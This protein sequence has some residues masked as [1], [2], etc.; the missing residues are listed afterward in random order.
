M[1]AFVIATDMTN[2]CEALFVLAA[3]SKFQDRQD[4]RVTYIQTFQYAQDDSQ[5]R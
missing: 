1:H 5:G 2:Y 3:R 4:I